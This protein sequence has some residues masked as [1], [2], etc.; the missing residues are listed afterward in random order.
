M[1]AEI[2]K[3][4]EEVGQLQELPNTHAAARI[5]RH[6]EGQ[7]LRQTYY[8]LQDQH[9]QPNL[10][11]DPTSLLSIALHRISWPYGYKPIQLP[12]YDGSVNP[13]QFIMTYEAT[14]ASA[15]EDDPIME[16][17]FVM[18]CEGPVAN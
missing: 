13:A 6:H 10:P 7:D 12:K 5:S 17:S 2:Q 11:F 9:F 15:G 18:A 16:K 1:Q 14:I 8:I 3:M 4:Q